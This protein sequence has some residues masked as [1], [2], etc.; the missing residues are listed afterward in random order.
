M[1]K[2]VASL[3]CLL[4]GNVLANELYF[5]ADVAFSANTNKYTGPTDPSQNYDVGNDYTE[6][7]LQLGYGE[8]ADVKIQGY[9]SYLAYDEGIYDSTNEGLYEFG[10][11]LIKEFA[12][13]EDIFPFVKAGFGFGFMGV[14]GYTKDMATEVGG[15]LGAGVRYKL[16]EDISLKGGLDLVFRQWDSV[17]ANS[18][19]KQTNLQ[20]DSTKLYFGIEYTF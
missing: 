4:A 8:E 14:N 16:D 1:K 7:K 10:A 19:L 18:T 3:I 20:T 11:E 6:L 17:Y 9:F 2:I 13:D 5:G 12:Y 15:N